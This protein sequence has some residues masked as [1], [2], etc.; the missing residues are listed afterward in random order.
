MSDE[1]V[2]GYYN[3]MSDQFVS[4]EEDSLIDDTDVGLQQQTTTKPRSQSNP[5]IQQQEQAEKT[6][7]SNSK[8][9]SASSAPSP[10]GGILKK[11]PAESSAGEERGS[12]LDPKVAASNRN[13]VSFNGR[14]VY[15]M[16]VVAIESLC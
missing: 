13:R 7:R 11:S 5:T 16:H 4:L 12:L 1:E 8:L 14:C 15:G 9:R 6:T 3:L 10:R 2:G